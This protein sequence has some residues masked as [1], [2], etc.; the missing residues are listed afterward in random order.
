[1]LPSRAHTGTGSLPL[2]FKRSQEVLGHR[3]VSEEKF[4]QWVLQE[5]SGLKGAVEEEREARIAE[6]EDI[7]NA[8]NDY[9]RALQ[10]GLKVINLG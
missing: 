3:H 5:I 6:D 1:M 8:L 9:T 7:V 2:F 4:Q 10:E